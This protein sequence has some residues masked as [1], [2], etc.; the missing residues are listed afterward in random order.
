MV[1][2]FWA[3]GRPTRWWPVACDLGSDEVDPRNAAQRRRLAKLQ[4]LSA[5]LAQHRD[6]VSRLVATATRSI[7]TLKSRAGSS[8]DQRG[9]CN[10]ACSSEVAIA[11]RFFACRNRDAFKSH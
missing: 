8:R 11:A 6:Y 9:P 5:V 3:C 7:V 2:I 1:A 4:A 10:R